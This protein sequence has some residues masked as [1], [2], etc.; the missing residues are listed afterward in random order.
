MSLDRVAAGGPPLRGRNRGF[1]QLLRD[2]LIEPKSE[3]EPLAK[4]TVLIQPLKAVDGGKAPLLQPLPESGHISPAAAIHMPRAAGPE[5]PP[6]GVSPIPEV[7]QAG[8]PGPSPIADLVLLKPRIGKSTAAMLVHGRF[9]VLRDS[10]NITR[11]EPTPQ[12]RPGLIGQPV[13]TEVRWI[14]RD[15][16]VEITRPGAQGIHLPGNPEDQIE[17]HVVDASR[18]ELLD[19][20]GHIPGVMKPLKCRERT[21]VE[22]LG[23]EADPRD[24]RIGEQR[25][26][27]RCDGVRIG[28]D[29]PLGQ[30]M[31]PRREQRSQAPEQPREIIR[32]KVRGRAAADEHGFDAPRQPGKHGG[33]FIEQVVHKCAPLFISPGD[34]VEIAVVAPVDTKRH[35]HINPL[36][37]NTCAACVRE[38]T[39][40]AQKFCSAIPRRRGTIEHVQ[41]GHAKCPVTTPSSGVNPLRVERTFYEGAT[42]KLA[43]IMQTGTEG[44]RIFPI[45]AGRTVI[46]RDGRCDLRIAMPS[47]SD[48]HC[49][50]AIENRRAILLSN[51]PECETLLNGEPISKAD[52][53]DED[54]VCIGPV[55]FRVSIPRTPTNESTSMRIER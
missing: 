25:G 20:G 39:F 16:L 55:T 7:V 51:G 9:V 28:L 12:G 8:V 3:H 19:R 6:I 18:P 53:S 10:A 45:E 48:R 17:R 41:V 47:V 42:V 24:A 35:M 27:M 30:Q 2:P 5:R 54:V 21:R 13:A 14:K 4:A 52:L 22:G 33:R 11:I 23:A 49:E 40:G 29:G 15:G 46:G 32:R 31:S 37:N 1:D 34:R 50:I 44:D 26:D 43:L 36:Y 38:D